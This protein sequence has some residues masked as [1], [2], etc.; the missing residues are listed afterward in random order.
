MYLFITRKD[1]TYEHKIQTLCK[2]IA[3]YKEKEI[4]EKKIR[5]EFHLMKKWFDK[6]YPHI[7]K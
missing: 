4:F 2:V 1:A 6:Y 3:D 5:E 7:F